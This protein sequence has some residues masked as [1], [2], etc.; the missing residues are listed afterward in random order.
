MKTPYLVVE[1]FN[2]LPLDALVHV[3]L[4][5]LL[6]S[7]LNEDLLQTLVHKVDAELYARVGRYERLGGKEGEG[8]SG[9]GRDE[10]KGGEIKRSRE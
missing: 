6:Q 10:K 5:L 2:R 7:Q 9:S 1:V 3:L 4:L 8:R